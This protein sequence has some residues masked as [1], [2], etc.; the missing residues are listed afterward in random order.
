M[1]KEEEP[2]P[3]NEE[4]ESYDNLVNDLDFSDDLTLPVFRQ[5]LLVEEQKR[6]QRVIEG[7]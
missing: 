5:R 3:A 4:E 6:K 2:I 1:V 7:R